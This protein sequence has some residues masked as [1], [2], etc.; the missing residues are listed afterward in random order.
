LQTVK[1]ETK[2]RKIPLGI[3][4]VGGSRVEGSA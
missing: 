1:V 4:A 3:Q 2:E